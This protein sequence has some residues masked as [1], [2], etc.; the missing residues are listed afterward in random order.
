MVQCIRKTTR[1]NK[2][3]PFSHQLVVFIIDTLPPA[4]RWKVKII[5]IKTKKNVK[6]A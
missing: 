2:K 1:S 3:S 4:K 5:R 6:N